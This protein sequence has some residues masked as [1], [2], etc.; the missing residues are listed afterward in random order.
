MSRSRRVNKYFLYETET[1]KQLNSV[2]DNKQSDMWMKK[3]KRKRK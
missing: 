2:D 3:K 1:G